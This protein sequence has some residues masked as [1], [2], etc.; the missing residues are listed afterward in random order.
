MVEEGK[1]AGAWQ[2]WATVRPIAADLSGQEKN[3]KGLYA[4]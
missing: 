4:L 1:R 2:S 3:V